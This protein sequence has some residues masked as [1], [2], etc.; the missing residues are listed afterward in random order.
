MQDDT[1]KA[2]NKLP[3]GSDGIIQ[4]GEKKWKASTQHSFR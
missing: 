2:Q 1:K 4:W 3:V